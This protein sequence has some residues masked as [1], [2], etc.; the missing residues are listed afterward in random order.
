MNREVIE[1]TNSDIDSTVYAL[2]GIIKMLEAIKEELPMTSFLYL[3]KCKA[4][5]E[6]TEKLE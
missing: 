2:K 4:V 1:K 5:E 6:L 3:A